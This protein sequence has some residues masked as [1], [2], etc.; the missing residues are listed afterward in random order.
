VTVV[1]TKSRGRWE[2]DEPVYR[3]PYQR[4]HEQLAPHGIRIANQ[5]HIRMKRGEIS[6]WIFHT[7][8]RSFRPYECGWYHRIHY[9]LREVHEELSKF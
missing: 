1:Q 4:A 3:F 2:A 9:R 6:L 8:E 7:S 5:H